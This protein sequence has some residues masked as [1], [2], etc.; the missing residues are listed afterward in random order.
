VEWDAVMTSCVPHDRLAWSTEPGLI[1]QHTG[2]VRFR[3]NRG[4]GTTVNI[5]PAYTP[6]M[7]GVGHI[8]ASLFGADPKS[9]MDANLVRV[10][11]FIETGKSPA[12]AAA[13]QRY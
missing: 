4:G 3:A 10:K 5:Q 11:T 8:V 7:S 9:E 13:A 12:D 6:G 2:S 1:V